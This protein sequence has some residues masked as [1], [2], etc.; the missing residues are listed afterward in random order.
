M[1]SRKNKVFRDS[2]HGY[3]SVPVDYVEKFIDTEPF[4]RLRSI[5]QTGMRVLYP[6]ARHDRFVH[7]LGVYHLGSKAFQCFKNNISQD[8]QHY[9]NVY[10]DIN[11]NNKFWDK[12]QILFEIACL[13]HD[14][15]H[16]PFS[17]TLE[18]LYDVQDVKQDQDNLNDKLKS[19]IGS[20][21]FREDFK[22]QGGPHERM[23][24]LLVCTEFRNSVQ[25]ILERYELNDEEDT[26]AYN[27]V[28]FIS[29]MIIGCK[30]T[31]KSKTSSIKN[32]L[33]S[34]LN[35]DSI[36]VDS[37]DYIIRDARMSGIDNMSIDVDRLLGSLTLVEMTELKKINLTG[38][39]ISG[40]IL[41]GELLAL[42]G[43]ATLN[44]RLSGNTEA[45]NSCH[46]RVR[47][48][49]SVNGHYKI[50]NPVPVNVKSGRLDKKIVVGGIRFEEI[51]HP[52]EETS[53]FLQGELDE[54]LN[55]DGS[56]VVFSQESDVRINLNAKKVVFKNAQINAKLSGIFSGT[57]LGNHSNIPK[58]SVDCTL[59]FHKSSLS[60]I[61][62]VLIARNYE[63]Q[64]VY[65]HHKVVYYANYLLI[66]LLRE[67]V[68]TLIKISSN[69]EGKEPLTDDQIHA[70][71]C[72]AR[73][74]SW[75]TMLKDETE[76]DCKPRKEFGMFFWRPSDADIQ[77]VFRL[78][79]IKSNPGD[80]VFSLIQQYTDR[81]YRKSLWKSYAEMCIFLDSFTQNDISDI[82]EMLVDQSKNVIR[83]KRRRLQKQYGY[84]GEEWAAKF[85]ECGLDDV[86]WVNG[87]SK[88][89][90]LD[91]NKTFI[92]FK[93]RD[94]TFGAISSP[95]SVKPTQSAKLFYLYY[96]PIEDT[97]VKANELTRFLRDKLKEWRDKQK[98]WRE[99]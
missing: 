52:T 28:E 23:S 20:R 97:P 75:K 43:A 9:Y 12:C 61:Q 69:E 84:L 67:S 13:L 87:S 70:T 78:A 22:D 91:P 90:D 96:Q 35:S 76:P 21:E 99:G 44:G 62:N 56:S 63:Y 68:R 82:L 93:N 34:L 32:C 5:E 39:E 29:R 46:V 77:A 89:K 10:P 88:L 26:P 16:T 40:N 54:D 8:F 83:E 73:I 31:E 19:K 74:L 80:K 79:Q 55:I 36:D 15:A 81:K 92:R 53:I 4:Q 47:G 86:V 60:V 41:V 95:G 33:I 71:D 6:S 11:S 51:P 65:T 7:S 30:Y 66:E 25:T 1:R 98:E 48:T 27:A 3:I 85:R 49:V 57:L 38:E 2:V 59:G 58:A 50:E 24:A 64:W 14:C 42:Q 94:M 17:H 72:M 37:L 18:F 45:H